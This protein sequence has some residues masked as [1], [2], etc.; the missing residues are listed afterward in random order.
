[1]QVRVL[2]T[3]RSDRRRVLLIDSGP[4]APAA[5]ALRGLGLTARQAETLRLIALGR[6]PADAA[7][8]MGVTRRTVD[9]HLQNVYAVL[10][11]SDRARAVST[12]WA[13]IGTA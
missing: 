6:T 8:E 10:G 11:T 7:A 2:P 4:A 5:R 9:K 1:V 3:S 13:A 12:A